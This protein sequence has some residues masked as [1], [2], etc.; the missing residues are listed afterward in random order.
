M[1]QN[2]KA[3]YFKQLQISLP[4][5]PWQQNREEVEKQQGPRRRRSTENTSDNV[6]CQ[7]IPKQNGKA[8]SGKGR[9]ERQRRAESGQHGFQAQNCV[10]GK[11]QKQLSVMVRQW[12]ELNP[13][14]KARVFHFKG[15]DRRGKLAYVSGKLHRIS[16]SLGI[17]QG[18]KLK[19]KEKEN[20]FKVFSTKWTSQD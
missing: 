17:P 10:G 5:H 18:V 6:A 7:V 2:S 9:H 13:D 20:W 3:F 16:Q 4:N 8:N 15:R 1:L 14:Q 11:L 19:R 12:I